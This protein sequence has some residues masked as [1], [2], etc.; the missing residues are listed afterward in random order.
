MLLSVH[1]EEDGLPLLYVNSSTAQYFS[2]YIRKENTMGN[3]LSKCW[4]AWRLQYYHVTVNN[5]STFLEL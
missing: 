1:P 4:I 5:Q 2:E 3:S